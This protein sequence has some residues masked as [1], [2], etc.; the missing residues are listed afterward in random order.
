[1]IGLLSA[2]VKTESR[3]H[4]SES[5]IYNQDLQH[6]VRLELELAGTNNPRTVDVLRTP[7]QCAS[8]FIES[9][10]CSGMLESHTSKISLNLEQIPNSV[11]RKILRMV[12]QY[13]DTKLCAPT[14]HEA[15]PMF[16]AIDFL[17]P[18]SNTD[19]GR[20]LK[21]LGDACRDIIKYLLKPKHEEIMALVILYDVEDILNAD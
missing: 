19:E 9:A 7:M 15:V 2:S 14:L 21:Q 18:K 6:N 8:H 12:H 13:G 5:F 11:W 17:Q 4:M 10:L 16:A 3:I 1:M 20:A